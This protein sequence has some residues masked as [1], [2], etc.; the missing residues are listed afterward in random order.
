MGDPIFRIRGLELS[1]IL[2]LDGGMSEREQAERGIVKDRTVR[3]WKTGKETQGTSPAMILRL[4]Q[5]VLKRRVVPWGTYYFPMSNAMWGLGREGGKQEVV[6]RLE[7]E[8]E[9][10]L[11]EK[12]KKEV[13]PAR[14]KALS[15]ALNRLN[16]QQDLA[17][18]ENP[19]KAQD[20]DPKAYAEGAAREVNRHYGDHAELLSE[21]VHSGLPDP[22]IAPPKV[23]TRVLH[24][25][26][27]I[28]NTHVLRKKDRLD[29]G[30]D[31]GMD[32]VMY[33]ACRDWLQEGCAQRLDST[34]CGVILL[35]HLFEA[36]LV[37][38]W[39]KCES[40]KAR[41]KL[42]A[43]LRWFEHQK[44]YHEVVQ[45]NFL[46][47]R[48]ALAVASA[49]HQSHRY[50]HWHDMLVLHDD[51]WNNPSRM[52]AL[53]VLDEDFDDY[54]EWWSEQPEPFRLKA[55]ASREV[56]HGNY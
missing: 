19:L 34:A 15:E 36:E 52:R 26:A 18:R 38:R 56:R 28:S 24:L 10:L 20:V 29:D 4:E 13:R 16:E 17:S 50:W 22:K 42:L 11:H 44:K 54:I 6:R 53:G 47:A 23:W 7:I 2:N 46:A 39:P 43:E 40:L 32:E 12:R 41:R 5:E 30:L 21:K 35:F 31:N 33:L 37:I 14:R 9:R 55:F 49:T 27:Y 25:I 8:R 51:A 45:G 48:N 3:S 1:A